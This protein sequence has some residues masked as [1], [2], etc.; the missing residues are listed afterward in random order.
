MARTLIKSGMIVAMDARVGDLSRGDVL[1]EDD[2]IAAIALAIDAG[3]ATVI[4]AAGMIVMPGFVNAHIHTWQ[5]ALRGIAA[6]WTI[7]EY[8]HNMHAGLAPSFTPEDVFIS[9][10]VGALNQLDSGV[11]TLVDWCHNNPTPAHTDA[12]IEGLGEVGIRAIFLHG[13]PKPDPK[14]GQPHFSEIPHPRGEVERLTRSRFAS[15]GLVTLGMAVLGPAYSTYE[16]SRHDLALARELDMVCSM[17]VGGGPMR[18][19]DGFP[20]LVAEGLVGRHVNIVHGNNLREDQLRPLI[21]HGASV[22]VTPECEL[23][24]GF[25]DCLTGRLRELGS[26]PSLGTDVESSLGGDMFTN[27]RMALQAQRNV[28]NKAVIAETGKAPERISITCR[29]A[30]EWATI[31]GARMLGLDHQIGSLAP[32]KQADIVLLRADDLNL[33]PVI[34]PVRSIVL[35]AALANVDTVLV[36]GHVVKRHG[37]LI[38]RDLARRKSELATT[39][40][41][42]RARARLTH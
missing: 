25:G 21:D 30:L 8:L 23:Q 3:E 20:R 6:D 12:A 34:D 5:T 11:T 4:D 18:T 10:L 24:M 32:G 38:Y 33:T 14:P 41:A 13:S 15:N 42:V 26:A 7:P 22:T 1:I 35:H 29:E 16:V 40:A 36:A 28:D 27:M 39:S 31:A 17:H 9:N 37:K 19:P 2:R